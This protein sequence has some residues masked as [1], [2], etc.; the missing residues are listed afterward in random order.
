MASIFPT[1]TKMADLY[2]A[3][4]IATVRAVLEVF[5]ATRI[6]MNPT[7]ITVETAIVLFR[8]FSNLLVRQTCKR[9]NDKSTT[10]AGLVRKMEKLMNENIPAMTKVH[11]C[12]KL[13]TGVGPSIASGSHIIEIFVTD[14]RHKPTR[15][16]ARSRMGEDSREKPIDVPPL[17]KSGIVINAKQNTRSTSPTRLKPI[18][19]NPDENVNALANQVVISRKLTNP[20][21]SHV[22]SHP[23]NPSDDIEAQTESKKQSRSRLKRTNVQSNSV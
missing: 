19:E 7:M 16:V 11:E 14:F 15:S 17:V 21:I 6:Q 20:M 9:L 3:W 2:A 22:M 8:S 18:A 12:S 13:D 10:N 4:K 1:P 23:K 5:P